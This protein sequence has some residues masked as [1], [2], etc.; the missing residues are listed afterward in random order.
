MHDWLSRSQ[1]L[2]A[3]VSGILAGPIVTVL[4]AAVVYLNGRSWDQRAIRNTTLIA[5]CIRDL[6]RAE[7]TAGG[8]DIQTLE[9]YSAVLKERLECALQQLQRVQK[10]RAVHAGGKFEEPTGIQRWLLWYRPYGSAAWILHWSFY[11]FL[12]W[13]S[14]FLVAHTIRNHQP[15]DLA[16]TGIAIL[17]YGLLALWLHSVALRCRRLTALGKNQLNVNHDL[18][19]ARRLFLMFEPPGKAAAVEQIL[20]YFFWLQVLYG[21]WMTK[22]AIKK[23]EISELAVTII[24]AILLSW[25]L[26]YDVWLRRAFARLNTLGHPGPETVSNPL[27]VA[28]TGVGA[29]S[30]GGPRTS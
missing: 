29:A 19:W 11:G 6:Q 28:L 15:V 20:C 17:I 10:K 16:V 8:V 12:L 14:G 22:D 5:Q 23:G 27:D 3:A 4:K 9:P 24:I 21:L 26:S 1:E 7:K 25:I 13:A 2:N 30:M 18:S